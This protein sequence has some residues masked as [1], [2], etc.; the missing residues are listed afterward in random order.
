ML[1]SLASVYRCIECGGELAIHI[2]E[3]LR[4]DIEA[5]PPLYSE[6]LNGTL[7]CTRCSRIY[8]IENTVPLFLPSDVLERRHVGIWPYNG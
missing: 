8:S 6:V 7:T 2:D 5:T 4:T 1:E 3:M